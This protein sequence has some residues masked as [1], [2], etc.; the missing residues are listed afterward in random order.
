MSF[1]SP[2]AMLITPSERKSEAKLVCPMHR[3]YLEGVLEVVTAGLGHLRI[4]AGA[5]DISLGGDRCEMFCT[6][7]A[8]EGQSRQ[9][10]NRSKSA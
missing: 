7:P 5:C 4:A 9:S 3:A 8:E 10:S 2:E 6:M 1:S